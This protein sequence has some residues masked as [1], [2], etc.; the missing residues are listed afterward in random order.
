MLI[1]ITRQLNNKINFNSSPKKTT[2]MLVKIL[3]KVFAKH[4]DNV[5]FEKKTPVCIIKTKKILAKK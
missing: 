2:V 4:N 5:N 1:C 3:V